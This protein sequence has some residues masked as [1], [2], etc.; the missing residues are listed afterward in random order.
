MPSCCVELIA[1]TFCSGVINPLQTIHGVHGKNGVT[2]VKHVGSSIISTGRDGLWRVLHVD[3]CEEKLKINRQ[4][5]AAQ[6]SF[7]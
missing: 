4:N 7:F 2:S 1:N 5:K 6:V 3:F